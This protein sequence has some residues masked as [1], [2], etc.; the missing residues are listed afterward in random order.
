MR[1]RVDIIKKVAA[2]ILATS[3]FLLPGLSMAGQCSYSV[4]QIK[5]NLP[6]R[7]NN[8]V[9]V[10]QNQVNKGLCRVIVKINSPMGDRFIPVY[11]TP[12]SGV[13]V[14][15]AYFV[16]KRDVTKS[17][18]ANME[19]DIFKKNFKIYKKELKNVAIAEYKPKNANGKRLYVFMDPL[20]PFCKLE[21]PKLKGLADRSG[22]TIDLIPFVVHGKPALKKVESFICLHKTFDD[23]VSGNFGSAKPCAK[24]TK[25]LMN[26]L[27]IDKGLQLRG[28]PT[29]VTSDGK[30]ATGAD[31]RT[32]KKMLGIN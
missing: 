23:Y 32:L 28:T 14:G 11:V 1:I 6:L 17:E 19:M 18:I 30:I 20:C 27:R 5:Q 13:I 2:V 24:S 29:F 10:K 9:V 26:A 3:P 31:S 7:T 12:N 25:L 22:Y 4:K 21:S 8:V 15:G 16:N